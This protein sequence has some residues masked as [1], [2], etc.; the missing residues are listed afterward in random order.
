MMKLDI[1]LVFFLPTVDAVNLELLPPEDLLLH[2]KHWDV[3]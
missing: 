3:D 2:I 1:Q